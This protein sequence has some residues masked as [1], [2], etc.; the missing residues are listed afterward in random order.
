MKTTAKEFKDY[1]D[2]NVEK[3]LSVIH[4]IIDNFASLNAKAVGIDQRLAGIHPRVIKTL[5]EEGFTVT[6]D[7]KDSDGKIIQHTIFIDWH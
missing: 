3:Q 5:K 4:C 7:F 2:K 6:E 1:V